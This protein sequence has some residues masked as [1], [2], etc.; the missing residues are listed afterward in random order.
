MKDLSE[1]FDDESF[2][3]KE[4]VVPV[5]EIDFYV[6]KITGTVDIKME[7]GK[8]TEKPEIRDFINLINAMIPKSKGI[9][10]SQLE[11]K[12]NCREWITGILFNTCDNKENTI[13]Y[14]LTD[15][16]EHMNTRMREEDKYALLISFEDNLVLCHSKFGQKTMTPSYKFVER[17]LDG[18]VVR[19]FILFRR[20]DEEIIVKH[21]EMIHSQFFIE[22]LGIPEQEAISY[23]HGTNR[24]YFE[25]ESLPCQIELSDQEVEAKLIRGGINFNLDEN[26]I[27]LKY[28]L[29][30]IHIDR[31]QSHRT[32]YH[33]AKDFMRSFALKHY[34]LTASQNMFE[35]LKKNI[36]QSLE[37]VCKL[38]RYIDAESYVE[39][40][41]IANTKGIDKKIKDSRVVLFNKPSKDI[42][43]IF[44]SR[45]GKG[46][47]E[48][49][50]SYFNKIYSFFINNNQLKIFHAGMKSCLIDSPFKLKSME[51]YNQIEGSDLID[52]VVSHYGKGK[53]ID[54]LVDKSILYSIFLLL[55]ITIRS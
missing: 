22:W 31:I 5:I 2:T 47:I 29:K 30:M 39:K 18:D 20:S 15:F 1:Y 41:E 28:P 34:G 38:Y 36:E 24:F 33:D 26:S 19:R 16:A 55:F 25:V 35:L 53:L 50:P 46:L 9:N 4:K 13:K 51:I 3:V 7:K 11:M 8:I 52:A 45:I 48:F 40:Y 14:L 23:L 27:Q 42:E 49:Q 12:T 44:A 54:A 6:K 37:G 43:I 21:F 10:L 17:M 32:F